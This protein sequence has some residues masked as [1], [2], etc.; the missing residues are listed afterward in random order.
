MNSSIDNL[1]RIDG[2]VPLGSALP[3]GLQ[4]VLAMFVSN[5]TPIM[6]LSAAVGLDS[7]VSATL[8]QNCMVVAGIGTLI[9]LFPLGRI[10]SRLPI[11]MGISFTF[12]SL[13]ISIA[14]VY[15]MGT[16]IGAVIVGGLV[17]GVARTVR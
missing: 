15:G 5:I 13:A 9:Q 8:I 17:E 16:L 2:R 12:L 3:F 1:Y 10:G 4:H 14:G 7:T 11:V 6:I